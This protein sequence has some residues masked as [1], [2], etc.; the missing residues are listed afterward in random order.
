MVS[1]VFTVVRYCCMHTRTGVSRFKTSMSSFYVTFASKRCRSLPSYHMAIRRS[2]PNNL[3]L[4]A[5]ELFQAFFRLKNSG[6]TPRAILGKGGGR[7]FETIDTKSLVTT[8]Y[9]EYNKDSFT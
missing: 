7:C 3:K 4:F 5:M 2:G 1:G 9:K 6:W 8:S